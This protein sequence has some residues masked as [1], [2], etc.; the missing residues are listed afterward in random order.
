MEHEQQPSAP[1]VDASATL[2]ERRQLPLALYVEHREL[3]DQRGRNTGLR[4]CNAID[5]IRPDSTLGAQLYNGVWSIWLKSQDAY[6]QLHTIKLLD[7]DNFQISLHEKY[8]IYRNVPNEKVLFKD[9]PFWVA[10]EDIVDYLKKQ[11]GIQ[12]KSGVQFAHFRDDQNKLSPYLSGDRF[13]YVKGNIKQALPDTITLD[14]NRCRVSHKTQEQVCAR[15]R[16]HGHSHRNTDMCS[17]YRENDGSV[18]TIRSPK[19][20]LCNYYPCNIKFSGQNFTSLEQAYQWRFVKYVGITQL[21]DEILN[22]TTPQQA[23]DIARRVPRHLHGEWHSIKLAVMKQLL[24]AKADY[25]KQFRNTLIMTAGKSI[26]ESTSDVFWSSGLPPQDSIT[27]LPDYYP[28]QNFLGKILERV[29]SELIKEDELTAALLDVNSPKTS[30]PDQ[31]IQSDKQTTTATNLIHTIT[32]PT[33]P[34]TPTQQTIVNPTPDDIDLQHRTNV[35]STTS[36]QQMTLSTSPNDNDRQ[37]TTNVSSINSSSDIDD[38][39]RDSSSSV[40]DDSFSIS[41]VEELMASPTIQDSSCTDQLNNNA[42]NNI[43]IS[44]LPEANKSDINPTVSVTEHAATQ[45]SPKPAPR[46]RI[47]INRSASTSSV[48]QE[49][50]LMQMFDRIKKRKMTPLKDAD[51]TRD[52]IKAQRSDCST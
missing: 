10:N 50:I 42:A 51:T 25:C 29:R 32:P 33:N 2:P 9:L 21:A 7:F 28:G 44:V 23:K 5:K 41:G 11:P 49:G 4:L 40:T 8:P 26:V 17:A 52:G 13:I 6:T 35:S 18:V 1:S 45:P 48:P 14:Y 31:N 46:R 37:R 27:T 30:N 34:N 38:V 47:T 24:H 3:P 12:I 43:P 36:T 39:V 22:S 20:V 16:K 15:C 19:F